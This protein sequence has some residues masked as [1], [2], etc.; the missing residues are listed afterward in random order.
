MD[1]QNLLAQI[2][3][4]RSIQGENDAKN[5]CL[6]WVIATFFDHCVHD[7]ERNAYQQC[8]YMYV[9][10]PEEKA[11]WFAH[12]DVVPGT[13]D[14]FQ[15]RKEG[16]KLYG[17]GT[18][19]MK[20]P[21]LSLL[22]AWKESVESGENPAVSILLTT[23]EEMGGDTIDYV[24]ENH[25]LSPPFAYTPDCSGQDIIVEHKAGLWIRITIYGR[26]AHAAMPWE[27]SNAVQELASIIAKLQSRFPVCELEDWTTTCTPT[28]IQGGQAQNQVPD[29][30]S[31]ECDIR[32]PVSEFP[33]HEVL[34]REN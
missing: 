21:A 28:S 1:I 22:L 6:D 16:D 11:L 2:V 4:F 25:Q 5:E 26:S 18:K 27:G 33:D 14:Q 9:K 23:D 20:G 8:P 10:H 30:A 3:S 7:T 24:I 17:R 32:F 29:T 31:V 15:L 34:L 13:D 12:L 19:D